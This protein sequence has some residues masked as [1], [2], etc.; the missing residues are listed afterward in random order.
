MSKDTFGPFPAQKIPEKK[1]T[2]KWHEECIDHAIKLAT[3]NS[4]NENVRQTT[5]N[6]IIN[7]NLY[8]NILDADDMKKLSNPFGIPGYSAPSQPQNHPIANTKIDLLA[9]EYMKRKFPYTVR[10]GDYEAISEKEEELSS[11]LE[12]MF[13][14]SVKKNLSPEEFEQ[15]FKEYKKEASTFQNKREIAINRALTHEIKNLDFEYKINSGFFDWLIASEG[16]F[17]CDVVG[18][19]KYKEIVFKKVNP[20]AIKTYGQGDSPWIH[21]ADIIVWEQWL[22]KGQIQDEY[23]DCLTDKDIAKL[24]GKHQPKDGVGDKSPHLSTIPDHWQKD[25]GSITVDSDALKTG[26]FRVDSDVFFKD[27]THRV[28]KVY[29]KSYREMKLVYYYDPDTG[30]KLMDLKDASYQID[31]SLGETEETIYIIEWRQSTKISRDIYKKMGARPIQIRNVNNPSVCYPPII[32]GCMNINNSTAMSLM[33]RMKPYIYI[34]N[35][36]M[37]RTLNAISLNYGKL[38]K[39]SL[40]DIPDG[41]KPSKWLKYVHNQKIWF[42]DPFKEG[43]KGASTGKLSG[44]MNQTAPVVDMELGSYIQYHISILEYVESQLGQI[45][46]IPPQREASVQTSEQVGNVERVLTQSSHITEK[47]FQMYDKIKLQCLKILVET[48]KIVYKDKENFKTQTVL[49]NGETE[50]FNIDPK[51]ISETNYDIHVTNSSMEEEL[52]RVLKNQ[53]Q[54]L[55]QNDKADISDL[56]TLYTN[57]SISAITK[58]LEEGQQLRRE[59]AGQAAKAEQE[60]EMQKLIQPKKMEIEQKMQE[61][62]FKYAE[63]QA[64]LTLEQNKDN[65]D[66]IKTMT[67]LKA[68]LAKLKLDSESLDE[69]IRNNKEKEKLESKK[70]SKMSKPTTA[71]N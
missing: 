65:T 4:F 40:Q 31:E 21:D 9:G 17:Y 25:I 62:K 18:K 30:E 8:N 14:E 51:L 64:N 46:G 35:A 6:K 38:M 47:W 22:S 5:E 43:K 16:V 41:W 60:F 11:I 58:K 19:G 28:I 15:K 36:I 2:P 48:L 23:W 70:I 68:T 24:D 13:M 12:S 29:W 20:V 56:I 61:L 10:V 55:I 39:V 59:Q 54:A 71:K 33:D 37:E 7:Y 26:D 69:T 50:I 49:D 44:H 42:W 27:G 32:G 52:I 34:Y 63:L 66:K 53:T 45:A 67:D 1:K 3:T 57:P